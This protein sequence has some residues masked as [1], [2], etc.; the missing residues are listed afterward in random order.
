MNI[1]EPWDLETGPLA[2][3]HL[4][5]MMPEFEPHGGIKDPEKQAAF[6]DKKK[7][8]WMDDAAKHGYSCRILS[9]KLGNEAF[10]GVNEE[11]LLT[12][13]ARA[14]DD[15]LGH[16]TFIVGWNISDFD[17]PVFTQRCWANGVRPPRFMDGRY[18]NRQLVDLA[19]VWN[20]GSRS[21]I[22]SLN[23]AATCLGCRKKNGS[24][25]D[26]H[27]NY[28]SGDPEKRAKAISYRDNDIEMIREVAVRMNIQLLIDNHTY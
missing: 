11:D 15:A 5:S 27:K 3:K 26:F 16:G 1:W 2:E 23:T 9:H 12:H 7:E 4:F 17:V 18:Q 20:A 22:T 24:G 8:A 19:K 28:L 21:P 6:L 25:A 10:D 13:A 14:L